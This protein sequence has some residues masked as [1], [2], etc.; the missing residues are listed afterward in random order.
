MVWLLSLGQSRGQISFVPLCPGQN[1]FVPTICIARTSE[2]DYDCLNVLADTV[3]FFLLSGIDQADWFFTSPANGWFEPAWFLKREE[4][5]T[6]SDFIQE[7]FFTTW[8]NRFIFTWSFSHKKKWEARN[9]QQTWLFTTW[10]N[11]FFLINHFLTK[12][13]RKQETHGRCGCSR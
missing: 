13:N 8:W 7:W 2:Q 1:C 10:L 4:M 11:R 9:T 12:R 6:I 3:G 5:R